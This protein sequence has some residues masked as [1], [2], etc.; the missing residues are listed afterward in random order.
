MFRHYIIVISLSFLPLSKGLCNDL[1]RK[2]SASP[3]FIQSLLPQ[4]T[5][6]PLFKATRRPV[7]PTVIEQKTTPIGQQ[8]QTVADENKH[9]SNSSIQLSDYILTGVVQKGT[10]QIAILK[11][12]VDGKTHLIRPGRSTLAARN[13][14]AV[15][16]DV[17]N[18]ENTFI[19]FVAER[20][21]TLRIHEPSSENLSERRSTDDLYAQNIPSTG[22]QKVSQVILA[23]ATA[24]LVPGALQRKVFHSVGTTE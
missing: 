24:P 12:R 23:E 6:R 18:I 14:V 9:A 15:E 17:V 8:T 7:M 10:Q 19:T 5:A 13:G 4:T 3:G 21:L 22:T 16:I 11:S 20:E 2:S 1:P